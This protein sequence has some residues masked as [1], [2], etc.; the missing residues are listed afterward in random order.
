[1]SS[2]RGAPGAAGPPRPLAGIRVIDLAQFVAG[3]YCTLLLGD[4]GADV[5]KVELP[6]GDPYRAQGPEF[7]NGEA[8]LFLALNRNKRGVVIDWKRPEGLAILER[9]LARADV[10]VEN[11]RP[12]ALAKHGLDAT[13]ARARHPRLVHCSISGYGQTG[14]YARRGGFDLVLQ[15][16]GGLMSITGERD[17]PPVK[18]GAPILDIGAALGAALGVATALLE[19]ERTGRGAMVESSLLDFSLALLTTVAQSF[20]AS[21]VEPRRLGSASPQFAP[22]QA[23][24][25]RDGHLTVA[26]AGSEGMWQRFCEVL[27][28][29]DLATDERF[30][31]NADR[32][33]HQEELAAI[34]EAELARRTRDEWLRAFEAGEVP[35]GPIN[36]LAALFADPHVVARGATIAFTHPAAGDLRSVAAPVRFGHEPFAAH[37]A[38]PALGQHTHEVLT[39]YGLGRA[40]L[41]TLARQG[42]VG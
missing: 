11:A 1:L 18:V 32:V 10:L 30:R 2:D 38:P 20:F 16:E 42:I 22:Y 25:A 21:G 34:V 17:G 4:L 31:T 14:P 37:R 26:G 19:R 28:R 7:T 23:F 35:A 3:S 27:G 24:R 33:A 36:G 39:E 13:A 40:E 6:G 15:G 9:L 8:S 29:A 12:G 41:E 5:V